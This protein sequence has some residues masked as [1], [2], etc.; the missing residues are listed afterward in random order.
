MTIL[1]KIMSVFL[2]IIFALF[3]NFTLP[4]RQQIENSPSAWAPKIIEAIENE[5]VDSL[6]DM[7]CFS[8][9]TKT[10]DLD[11]KI[12]NFYDCFDGDILETSWK[13]GLAS[14]SKTD[15]DG[16]QLHEGSFSINIITTKHN[17]TVVIGWR[18]VDTKNPQ[19]TKIRDI[20]VATENFSGT[21]IFELEATEGLYS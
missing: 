16:D 18:N 5:D 7:M 1:R 15:N 13:D 6:K 11:G 17:Y 4:L 12:R 9:K 10:K 20:Y 14:S 21:Y 8:L 2:T 19:E 3:P